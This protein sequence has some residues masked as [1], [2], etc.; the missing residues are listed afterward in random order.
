MPLNGSIKDRP[1]F[2]FYSKKS[3]ATASI[4][5]PLLVAMLAVTTVG[6]FVTWRVL[7]FNIC[8]APF[9]FCV[10]IVTSLHMESWSHKFRKARLIFSLLPFLAFSPFV[11]ECFRQVTDYAY[12]WSVVIVLPLFVLYIIWCILCWL[13]SLLFKYYRRSSLAQPN[14]KSDS[15]SQSSRNISNTNDE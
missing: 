13:V 14:D 5:L 3:F 12:G 9:Y 7:V 10:F 6:K 1:G 15:S 11:I 8:L 2:D 4:I